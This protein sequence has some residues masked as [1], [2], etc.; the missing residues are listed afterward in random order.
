VG[1]FSPKVENK[2]IES[3]EYT[4]LSSEIEILKTKLEMTEDKMRSLKGLVS[5]KLYGSEE[6]EENTQQKRKDFNS[7]VILPM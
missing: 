1:F 6:E 2:P 4:K 7:G 3:K 5:R